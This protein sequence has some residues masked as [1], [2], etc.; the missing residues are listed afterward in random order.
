MAEL[1]IEI[2]IERLRVVEISKARDAALQRLSEVYVSIRQKNEL[3]EQLQREQEGSGLSSA[4]QL[5]KS[6]DSA[7][8]ISLKAHIS[9]LEKSVE[10]LRSVIRQ[11]TGRS[12]I[13]IKPNDPPPCYE[14]SSTKVRY[15][16]YDSFCIWQYSFSQLAEMGIQTEPEEIPKPVEVNKPDDTDFKVLQRLTFV[17]QQLMK[18]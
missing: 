14:E 18:L 10:E 13:P 15:S 6:L 1:A 17:Y 5:P 11:Q 8:V 9:D 3:I 12:C 16:L 7:E 2:Q 4:I